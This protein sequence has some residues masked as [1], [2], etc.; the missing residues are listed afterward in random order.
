MRKSPEIFQPAF[1]G[2]EFGNIMIVNRI[3]K[4]I[5]KEHSQ[6]GLSGDKKTEHALTTNGQILFAAERNALLEGTRAMLAHKPIPETSKLIRC[7]DKDIEFDFNDFKKRGQ[8]ICLDLN[9]KTL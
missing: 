8:K 7:P 5:T 9:I 3:K 2:P 6:V 1:F 4:D